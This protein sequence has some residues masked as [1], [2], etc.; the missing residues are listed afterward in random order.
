MRIYFAEMR[1]RYCIER[2]WQQIAWADKHRV[3]LWLFQRVCRLFQIGLP[4]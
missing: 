3:R 2:I 1:G 4:R